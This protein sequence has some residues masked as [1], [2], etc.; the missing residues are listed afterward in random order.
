MNADKK[1]ILN[2]D[3]SYRRLSAF[4]GGQIALPGEQFAD[5]T[6]L[7]LA[8]HKFLIVVHGD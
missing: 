7:P 1:Q 4:I 8:S 6:R 3:L 2:L 5:G